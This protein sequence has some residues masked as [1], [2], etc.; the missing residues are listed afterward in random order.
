MKHAITIDPQVYTYT[1]MQTYYEK[2]RGNMDRALTHA[3][4]AGVDAGVLGLKPD[5]CPFLDPGMIDFELKWRW[6]REQS[7][8]VNAQQEQGNLL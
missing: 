8:K 2:N 5:E 6:G 4:C 7:L 3:M 1:I